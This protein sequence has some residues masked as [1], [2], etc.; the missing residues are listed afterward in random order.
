M[1]VKNLFLSMLAVA[2]MLAV[3]SCSQDDFLG[4]NTTGDYV[5]ATFTVSTADGIGTRATIGNGEIGR[6]HV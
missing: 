3:A 1:K 6:A 5:D 2:G 4:G